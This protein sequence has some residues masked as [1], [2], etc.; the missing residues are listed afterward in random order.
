LIDNFWDVVL[1]MLALFV[2]TMFFWMFIT[3]LADMWSDPDSSGGA[4]AGWTFFIVV[5]PWLGILIYLI[6]K[7]G[8]MAERAMKKQQA[9]DEYIR[10]VA[11][12]GSASELATLAELKEKG[13]IT[14]EEYSKAKASILA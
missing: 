7:G 11:G 12:A 13:H 9:H 10:K 6:A 3:V 1:W 14:E 8:G 5:L 4:K 2:F